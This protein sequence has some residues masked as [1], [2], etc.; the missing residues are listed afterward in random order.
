MIIKKNIILEPKQSNIH[1]AIIY[2]TYQIRKEDSKAI[3]IYTP[4]DYAIQKVK[5][6]QKDLITSMQ[7]SAQN[8]KI[9]TLGI[10]PKYFDN[11]FGYLKV[12]PSHHQQIYTTEKFIFSGK[13]I[14]NQ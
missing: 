4:V 2:A 1:L 3:V 7:Y 5:K 14:L 9:I 8:R 12:K 11:K 6:F 13:N 10:K